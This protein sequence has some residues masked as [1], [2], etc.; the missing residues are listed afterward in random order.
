MTKS[1]ALH[2]PI[3]PFTWPS[4]HHDKVAEI[5]NWDHMEFVPEIG[6]N[7]F[8]YIEWAELPPKE[9]LDRYELMIPPTEDQ[10]LMKIGKILARYDEKELWD[11]FEKAWDLARSKYGYSEDELEHAWL[12]F[13]EHRD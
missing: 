11:R 6:R 8:G 7:A 5:V 9:D 10:T 1:Y 4:E 2:R 13:S 3:G 12:R